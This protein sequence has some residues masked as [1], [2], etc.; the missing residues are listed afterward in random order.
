V[1]QH[2]NG[3]S[4]SPNTSRCLSLSFVHTASIYATP[5]S[6]SGIV[7]VYRQTCFRLLQRQGAQ[8]K[9]QDLLLKSRCCSSSLV[10]ETSGG[11]WLLS[12]SVIWH[13]TA[14][15]SP[16]LPITERETL[17]TSVFP[18]PNAHPWTHVRIIVCAFDQYFLVLYY[19]MLITHKLLHMI[20]VCRWM[21]H[22]P[23]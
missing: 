14:C 22:H 10:I 15:P 8:L 23:T 16:L 20:P 9:T 21:P 5:R 7:L 11:T 4:H 18:F 1:V 6:K 19:Y 3:D 17:T 12:S 2:A 13:T